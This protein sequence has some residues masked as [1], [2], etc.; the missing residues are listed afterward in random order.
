MRAI[1]ANSPAPS[2]AFRE[3][4]K[5]DGSILALDHLGL[6]TAPTSAG[7]RPDAADRAQ[8]GGSGKRT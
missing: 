4:R 5:Y 3:A 1:L 7:A 6:T 2:A 8:D